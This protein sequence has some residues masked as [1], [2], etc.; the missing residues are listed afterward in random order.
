MAKRRTVRKG[1]GPPPRTEQRQQYIQLMKQGYRNSAACRMV[2]VN[3]KTG[4]RWRHGREVKCG[5]GRTRSYAPVTEP[6][7]IS[8]RYLSADERTVIADDLQAGLSIRATGGATVSPSAKPAG[9]G[10]ARSPA[11][12]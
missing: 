3:R 4:H 6:V 2:E 10:R 8:D 9:R 1:P 12:R 7:V 11:S 5:D